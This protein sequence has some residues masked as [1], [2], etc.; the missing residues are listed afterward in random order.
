[1][2]ISVFQNLGSMTIDLIEHWSTRVSLFVNFGSILNCGVKQ[3][4]YDFLIQRCDDFSSLI[5]LFTLIWL[6]L[7]F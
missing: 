5:F 7:T 3:V 6:T 2:V 1:M 4:L